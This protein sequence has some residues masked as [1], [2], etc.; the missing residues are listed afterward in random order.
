[1]I[2]LLEDLKRYFDN[3]EHPT[4]E[5]IRFQRRLSEGGFPIASVHRDDLAESGYDVE[6]ISDTDMNE[7]AGR[8]ADDYCSLL[9]WDNLKSVADSL[10]FPKVRNSYCPSCSN[11]YIRYDA[12]GVWLC[13]ECGLDWSDKRYVLVEFPEESSYF[14][15]RDMGYPSFS[16]ADNG[17]RYV[18]EF[19][20]IQHFDRTPDKAELFRPVCWPESQVLMGREDCEPVQDEKGLKDFGTSSL[21]VPVK[22]KTT[23]R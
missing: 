21:W 15:E 16:S 20:Y 14:E 6:C 13:D 19:E 23:E 17:A 22:Y 12:E 7:L 8:M 9:F 4:K 1:M 3:K 5:E 18:P 11:K 10:E 2:Q